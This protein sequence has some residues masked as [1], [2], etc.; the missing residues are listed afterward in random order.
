LTSISR[1]WM[2]TGVTTERRI[3]YHSYYIHTTNY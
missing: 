2:K 1:R 3:A